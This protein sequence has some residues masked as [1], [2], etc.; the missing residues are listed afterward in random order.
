ME[1]KARDLLHPVHQLYEH[2]KCSGAHSF[3][4]DLAVCGSESDQDVVGGGHE[5]AP[6]ALGG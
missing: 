2:W 3:I 6:G 1:F 4:G 5:R